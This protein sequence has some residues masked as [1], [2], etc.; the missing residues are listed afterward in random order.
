MV[1]ERHFVPLPVELAAFDKCVAGDAGAPPGDGGPP[2]PDAGDDEDSGESSE[3]D[4][5]A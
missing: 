1:L 2:Q 5:G 3:D 4:A